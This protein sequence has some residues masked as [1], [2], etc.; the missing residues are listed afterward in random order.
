MRD[1]SDME[2]SPLKSVQLTLSVNVSRTKT[3]QEVSGSRWETFEVKVN[4]R[5]KQVCSLEQCV[6]VQHTHAIK[7]YQSY[8]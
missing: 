8:F 7:E 5:T 6:L 2:T 1:V 3:W 4:T